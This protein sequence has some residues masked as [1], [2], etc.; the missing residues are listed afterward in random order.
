MREGFSGPESLMEVFDASPIRK[1]ELFIPFWILSS[2]L[3]V[4]GEVGAIPIAT[5]EVQRQHTRQAYSYTQAIVVRLCVI[6]DLLRDLGSSRHS[7][8]TR[9][10]PVSTSWLR[11]SGTS[12]TEADAFHASREGP[13]SKFRMLRKPNFRRYPFTNFATVAANFA[14]SSSGIICAPPATRSTLAPG[15]PFL[16]SSA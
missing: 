3:L 1:C 9:R 14:G 5:G 11:A 10:I 4:R 13:N 7:R 15:I 12:L 2:P 6:I 16:N 8:A